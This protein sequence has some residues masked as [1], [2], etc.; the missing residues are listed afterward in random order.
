HMSQGSMGSDM[1]DINNDG[2]LDIFTTEMLPESDYRLKTTIKFD[3]YDV[4]NAKNQLDYHHQFTSN[5]LQLNNQDGTF[6]DIAQL[7]GADATGWSW[8]AL[9][10]DM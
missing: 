10:F 8:G 7:S 3:D 6:S 9:I 2:Y 1:A 4:V 5:C